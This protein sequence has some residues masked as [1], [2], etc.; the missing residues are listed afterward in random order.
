VEAKQRGDRGED[1]AADYLRSQGYHIVK[2]N[3]RCRSGEVDIVVYREES[4]VF[5]EVKHWL[6]VPIHDLERSID[7]AKRRRILACAREFLRAEPEWRR[8]AIRCDIVWVGPDE[9]THFPHAFTESGF[10]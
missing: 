5:V 9:I 7:H 2:R 1:L 4:L 8:F 6:S 10:L 3:L